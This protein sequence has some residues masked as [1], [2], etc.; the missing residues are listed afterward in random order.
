MLTIQSVSR[1]E[2]PVSPFYWAFAEQRRHE[3][4]AHFEAVRARN[5]SVWNGR[6]LL[7]RSPRIEGD[8]LRADYFETDF[9]SFLAWRDF[10]YPDKTV[11]NGFGTS[12]PRSADGAFIVG[13]MSDRTVNGGRVYFPAG[14]PE[15]GDVTG[16]HLDLDASIAREV[17]EETGLSASDY[18]VAPGWIVIRVRQAI[19]CYR[20]LNVKFETRMLCARIAA[21]I[22]SQPEPE[23]SAV[24][25]VASASDFSPQMPDFVIAFLE[26]AFAR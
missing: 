7:C 12:A 21:Y 19:A 26:R 23:L 20:L 13:R 5:P 22:D 25:P 10:G 16:G 8:C 17:R 18:D 1:L 2:C 24:L 6:V 11:F 15:P 9:A 3:I 4:A 14:T